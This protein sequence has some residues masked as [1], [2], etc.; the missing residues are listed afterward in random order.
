VT[1][2]DCTVA[3]DGEAFA[4]VSATLTGMSADQESLA[5][6][7]ACAPDFEAFVGI[8]FEASKLKVAYLVLDDLS[9]PDGN[10]L[11][12]VAGAPGEQL[13]STLRGSRR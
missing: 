12:I 3:H 6:G 7:K 8:P 13:T 4:K 10:V 11:C 1:V 2:T 5:A 9:D